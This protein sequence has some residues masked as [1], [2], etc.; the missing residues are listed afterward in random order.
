[1]VVGESMKTVTRDGVKLA[2]SE[3]GAGVPPL[4]FIHGWCCDHTYWRDQTPAFA[5]RHRVV[6]VDLRG[7]GVSDAPD[8]DSSIEQFREDV[9]WLSR[10]T[11]LDRP[12]I[13]GHSMGGLIALNIVRRWPEL[14]RAAVF[15][16]AVMMPFPEQFQ[17]MLASMLASLRSPGY[18]EV[19]TNF[20]KSFL[21]RPESPVEM[22][23][24]VAKRMASAPQRVMH[25]A[26]A[27]T[28]SEENM[29]AGPILVP[30]L[31]VRAET[32]YATEEQLKERYPGMEVVTMDAAHFLQMEKPEEFNRILR[33]FVEGLE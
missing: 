18:K 5:Q 3:A 12:V 4:L 10:E 15:V 27:D 19:A 9:A 26:L 20:V 23:D 8:E 16:D 28:I 11:S 7:L 31:F 17:P 14:A 32:A 24:D 29:V 2:Y 33:G 21:F 1:M 25:T 13:I 30:S 22:R 6:A